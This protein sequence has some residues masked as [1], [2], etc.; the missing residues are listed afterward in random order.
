LT[1]EDGY[2]EVPDDNSLDITGDLTIE[3]WIKPLNTS[4][5]RPIACK[6]KHNADKTAYYLAVAYDRIAFGITE[7]GKFEDRVNVI[8]SAVIEK[9]KWTHVAGTYNGSYMH[10]YINGEKIPEYKAL[11]ADSHPGVRDLLNKYHMHNFSI[12]LYQIEGKWYEFGYYEYTGDDFEGDMA[13]LDAEPRNKEWLTV[14]DPMQV[15]L[16]GQ[17]GWAE[18][19]MV[20]HND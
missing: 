2:I 6:M 19:E 1:G 12:F 16:E 4:D 9:N 11:P 14:C 20:Y 17:T 13:K 7:D 18:M 10:I 8:S 3:A 5:N 15:P